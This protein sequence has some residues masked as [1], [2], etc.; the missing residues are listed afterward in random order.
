MTT[1]MAQRSLS[2]I[3]RWSFLADFS[4]PALAAISLAAA[5]QAALIFAVCSSVRLAFLY[6]AARVW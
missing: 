4:S 2:W 1:S 5:A 6:R 3:A